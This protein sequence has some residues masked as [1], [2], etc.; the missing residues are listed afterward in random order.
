MRGLVTLVIVASIMVPSYP[1]GAEQPRMTTPRIEPVDLEGVPPDQW[2]V[3]VREG[4]AASGVDSGSTTSLVRTLAR[5]PAALSGLGPFARYIRERSMATVIDQAL[6]ALRVSWLSGSDA[7]WAEQA[8]AARSNGLTASDVRRV[9]EGPDAGWGDWDAS[10]LR[11]ADELYHDSYLSETTWNA[12]A[13][14]YNARQMLDVLFTGAE[15]IML[16][17]MA[18]SFGVQPDGRFTE[19]LPADVPR[20]I[21]MA[22]PS[23]VRLE[24]ARLEPLPADEWTEEQRALLDPDGT[25]QPTLNL[26]MTLVRSPALYRPRAVQS[27]YIRTQSTLSGR[28]R[29]MLILRIGWLCGAEYEWGQHAREARREGMTDD[30]I[31]DVAVGPT[32][33]P[34]TPIEAALLQ[35][36]DE[37]Y[38]DDTVSDATWMALAR[39][40]E[41]RG[42]IDIVVTVAGYRMVSMVLNSLGTQ[43]ETDREGFPNIPR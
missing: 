29:E 43:L 35:A 36:A 11:A 18:N 12:L 30:E 14:Q 1:L 15:H 37:L 23:P 21:E 5:H 34:W 3:D 27:R 41:Q 19:R 13:Q 40:Y 28:V 20:Q 6:L 31:R 32:A 10:V 17:M 9:A 42:L 26:F 7:M 38:Q 22:R 2:P 25:G 16:S 24:A 39:S 4:L 8:A 33:S